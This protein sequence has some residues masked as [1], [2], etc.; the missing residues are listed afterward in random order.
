MLMRIHNIQTPADLTASA[1]SE[2]KNV[3]QHRQYIIT[4]T[5]GMHSVVIYMYLSDSLSY[6]V[7]RK[8]TFDGWWVK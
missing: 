5:E 7:E 6:P 3:S 1:T 2:E 4:L 8:S